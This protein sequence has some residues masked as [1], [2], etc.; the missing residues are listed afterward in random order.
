[1]AVG[2]ATIGEVIHALAMT[3]E[4]R[5]TLVGLPL[6]VAG[7]AVHTVLVF[8]LQVQPGQLRGLMATLASR[9]LGGPIGAVGAVAGEAAA[10]KCAV[11][12]G[13]FLRMALAARLARRRARVRLV[14]IGASLVPGRR[15]LAF[16]C[17]AARA[18]RSQGTGMGL[19]A[20]VAAGMAGVHQLLLRMV[21]GIAADLDL[22]GMVRQALVAVAAR[23]VALVFRDVLH[24]FA[25]ARS[26]RG[27][28]RELE[29]E[30]VRLVAT[31]AGDVA[32]LAVL[33][34]QAGMAR[35][36]SG[37]DEVGARR[38]RM[39]VVAADAAAAS[40]VLEA[41]RVIGVNVLVAV[42]ARGLRCCLH[43]VR[44]MT[45]A[46]VIV[47]LDVTGAEHDDPLVAI[48]AGHGLRVFE[49][50]RAVAAGALRMS[51]FEGGRGR[52]DGLVLGMA[53]HAGRE[54]VFGGRVLVLVARLADLVGALA[55]RGM[56]GVDLRMAVGAGRRLGGGILVR[57][58]AA[59]ARLGRVRPHGGLG[60][61]LQG[62]ATLAVALLV[63][64]DLARQRSLP[65]VRE[66]QGGGL[67]RPE[68]RLVVVSG[69]FQ[70]EGVAQRAI[71]LGA[72]A[73]AMLCLG[74]RVFDAS[75]L[76]VARHATLR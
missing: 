18:G 15:R 20:L 54:R 66:R 31:G 51:A 9:H 70:R 60:A 58:V 57:S 7:V 52:H 37:R 4:A 43:V 10:G 56:L 41:I 73:E 55:L 14:A 45:I 24:L 27:Q 23:R 46:A 61:L 34:T 39:R 21:T 32:V 59:E 11:R 42:G 25:V 2:A 75:L 47:R 13:G 68:Q 6:V 65:R 33:R 69:A 26:A 28:A 8:R 17:V 1:M 16:R 49:L 22:L 63:G 3:A 40:P 19:V 67:R 36:A 44:R 38:V 5:F 71:G 12:T 74:T 76:G 30:L 72:R 50:M 48:A 64:P 53:V 29:P 35:S 62:V